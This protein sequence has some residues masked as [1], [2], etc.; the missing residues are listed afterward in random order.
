VTCT[1]S[2]PRRTRL[3]PTSETQANWGQV[4]RCTAYAQSPGIFLDVTTHL[5]EAT[6]ER[7]IAADIDKAQRAPPKRD[8]APAHRFALAMKSDPGLMRVTLREFAQTGMVEQ[9]VALL[10]VLSSMPIRAVE[11]IFV[12]GDAGGT[13]ILCRAL[14]LDFATTAAVLGL[15]ASM[16]RSGG[17]SRDSALAQYNSLNP[18]TARRVVRFWR[19][20]ANGM[21]PEEA[22]EPEMVT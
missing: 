18:E 15:R 9:S 17:L 7:E 3:L 20:R 8:Y 11:R 22:A 14:D 13:M 16:G 12:H 2:S 10:A 6:A 5:L 4:A 21:L 19:V 1:S